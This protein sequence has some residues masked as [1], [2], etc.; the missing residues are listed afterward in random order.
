VQGIFAKLTTVPNERLEITALGMVNTTNYA[1]PNQ[2]PTS[3]QD[4]R[5]QLDDSLL[6]LRSTAMLDTATVVSVALFVRC[7]QA[8]LTSSGLLTL[9]S[10]QY[11]RAITNNEQILHQKSL[12]LSHLRLPN[13]VHPN[14]ISGGV[15]A[16][17]ERW[18]RQRWNS[19][20]RV[21]FVC[22]NQY[23]CFKFQ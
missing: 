22:S 2:H 17:S 20:E 12:A 10:T 9:D 7:A 6:G 21:P 4:Q 1:I 8:E 23:C 5:H 19:D 16:P 14:G 15:C 13:A 18:Y 3:T 11:V